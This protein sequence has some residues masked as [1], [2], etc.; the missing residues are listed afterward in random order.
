MKKYIFSSLT[1]LTI[2]LFLFQ[3][4]LSN[5]FSTEGMALE[6]I[7]EQTNKYQKENILL[8]QTLAEY[9]SLTTIASQAAK[10]GFVS[11][12]QHAQLSLNAPQSLAI[13]Q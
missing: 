4:A 11:D 10:I 13:K 7:R 1:I 9:A 5:S 8:T 6:K 3:L 12:N 2:F